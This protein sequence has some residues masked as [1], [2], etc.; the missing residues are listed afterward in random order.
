MLDPEALT[1]HSQPWGKRPGA[2]QRPFALAQLLQMIP[3]CDVVSF[4]SS[5]RMEE[6]HFNSNPYFWPSIPTVSGQVRGVWFFASAPLG[7]F[8]SSE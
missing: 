2:P 1:P 8:F 6:S 3:E 4:P 7:T 5:G